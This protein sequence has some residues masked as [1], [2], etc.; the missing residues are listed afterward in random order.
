MRAYAKRT[1]STSA[2]TYR[3][4]LM[5]RDSLENKGIALKE[6]MTERSFNEAYKLFRTAKRAGEI[7]S[8][9]FQELMRK[10]RYLTTKQAKVLAKVN[11]ELTG[12]KTTMATAKTYG[13]AKVLALGQYINSLP[14]ED[15]AL[16]GGKYE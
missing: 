14:D 10:E 15:K 1:K 3:D 2:K 16:Y 12:E 11:E 13:Q 7:K 5:E 9:P 6:V 8:Q 4:Y